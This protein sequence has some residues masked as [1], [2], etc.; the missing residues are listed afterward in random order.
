MS[1]ALAG[2]RIVVP[3][4]RELD[5]L[6]AM[7]ERQGAVAIRCPMVAIHDA[8]DAAP[9]EDW[10][11]RFFQ[12]PPDA[13]VLMTGEGLGRL[14]GFA[15]RAGIDVE[16]MAALAKVRKISRGPKPVRRLRAMGLEAD[17]HVEP[18]TSAG[19]IAALSGEDLDGRRIAVQLYPDDP[20]GELLAFL[21]RKGA[22][23]DAVL[24]YRYASAAEDR[25]VVD[26]IDQM[27]AGRVDLVTFTSAPQIRRL[28]QVAGHHQREAALRDA[29][30]RTTIAAVGPVVARAIEDA[31]GFVTIVP[32]NN[33]HL[34]PMVNAII[35]AVG[36]GLAAPASGYD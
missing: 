30:S 14:V 16:F 6:V 31:G 23:I 8:A 7:L 17:L 12:Q 2:R 10:L 25:Q 15:Q 11:R 21:G 36:S 20:R 13:F 29:L 24:P 26:V 27:A 18:A 5:L 34:K 1:A 3:E 32:S 4:A 28:Q 9:V 33:F 35:A 19:V 22:R